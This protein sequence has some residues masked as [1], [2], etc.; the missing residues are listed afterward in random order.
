MWKCYSTC[1]R[2]ISI[3]EIP[4]IGNQCRRAGD[5]GLCA[6]VD[7]DG[8]RGRVIPVTGDCHGFYSSRSING[9]RAFKSASSS[10][11]IERS[12]DVSTSICGDTDIK[13]STFPQRCVIN[14]E[15][16]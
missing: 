2:E 12:I 9:E 14:L 16:W 10:T 5:S 3:D 15:R 13:D 4:D 1:I 11:Y 8:W 6:H 7:R